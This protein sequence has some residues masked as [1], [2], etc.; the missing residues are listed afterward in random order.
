MR[1]IFLAAGLLIP[2]GAHAH[3]H[4]TASQ[5][6]ENAVVP[7]VTN[8]RLS[9]TEALD[10]DRSTITVSTAAGP[11]ALP[12]IVIDPAEPKAV[13]LHLAQ[14]LTPG[15][16]TVAWHAIAAR[17]GHSTEGAYA[18]TVSQTASIRADQP[19]ARATAPQQKVGGAYVTLTSP[20]NDRLLGATSPVA[21]KAEVHEM[22]MDGG[23][24]RMREQVDGLA[25]PAGR[26]V[27]LA[28]GGLHIMLTGLRQ[29]LVAGQTIP[30]QLRF[31]HAPPL[32]LELRVAPIGAQGPGPQRPATEGH[33][34]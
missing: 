32:D 20:V 17:N 24:M 16:Y 27:T 21:S 26:A 2:A 23:V 11:V 14:P 34:H 15:A 33:T 31:E 29:P 28:P 5:P 4:L 6:S 8:L 3:A 19:W 13:L 22:T 12:P 7:P 9:Y 30:V 18:F 10:P 1:R 25:L